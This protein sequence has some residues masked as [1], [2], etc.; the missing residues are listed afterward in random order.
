VSS[1]FA[2]VD[3]GTTNRRIYLIEDGVVARAERDGIGVSQMTPEAWPGEV[4][5]IRSRFGVDKV[6]LAG[7]VGSTIGWR[8]VPYVAVPAGLAALAAGVVTVDTETA[9][10]PGVSVHTSTRGDVMRGEEVQFLGAVAARQVPEDALLCQPGTHCKW[11]TI[12]D[13]AIA[14]FRTTMTGELFALLRHHSILALQ[15]RGEV[16]ADDAFH[17]GV[18]EGEK[19]DLAASLFGARA[20]S[21]LGI[22]DDA[23]AASYVSGLL[24][25]GDVA[26]RLDG[27]KCVVHIIAD[28]KLGLLYRSA[29]EQLGGSATVID[30]EAAFVAG[31][32]AI[33]RRMQ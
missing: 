6:L 32:V 17:E 24:I 18:A 33:E 8:T 3:W 10:V 16:T 14:D 19:R 15:L 29:V 12:R 31:I 26:A 28:A 23:A 7:M 21:V 20:A 9:I 25:G 5:A 27:S 1:R 2:A 13:G 22:R 4:V 11:A 30:G